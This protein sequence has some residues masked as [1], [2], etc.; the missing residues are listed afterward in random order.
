[1]AENPEGNNYNFNL[2]FQSDWNPP[3]LVR[4]G[5]KKD[6]LNKRLRVAKVIDQYERAII[7]DI[8]SDEKKYDFAVDNNEII[9]RRLS[10]GK[11]NMYAYISIYLSVTKRTKC[12]HANRKYPAIHI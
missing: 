9:I 2:S 4:R 6:P 5:R 1:M 12:V 10:T 8:Q 7:D 11:S 3:E